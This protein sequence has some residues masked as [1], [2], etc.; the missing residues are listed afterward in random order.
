ML[1]SDHL[2]RRRAKHSDKSGD[3]NCQRPELDT[4]KVGQDSK[5]PQA[6]RFSSRTGS[7]RR[8]WILP[9][10]ET[11]LELKVFWS[12]V[13][14]LGNRGDSKSSGSLGEASVWTCCPKLVEG[15]GS[16]HLVI[17]FF[18]TSFLLRHL[19]PACA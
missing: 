2:H 1:V 9:T 11:L 13:S 3:L 8:T 18:V 17:G 10:E 6:E 14:P 12:F 15:C 16:D 5:K 7:Y 19:S 4:H